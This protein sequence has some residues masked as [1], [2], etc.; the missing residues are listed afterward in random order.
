[1]SQRNML[2]EKMME[3]I[4]SILPITAIVAIVCFAI[5]PVPSGLMLAFLLGALMMIVGMGLF[6]LGA[7]LSM[8]KIGGHIGSKMTTTRK[9]WLILVLLEV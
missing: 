8:S 4:R 5:V 1:M 3:S 7:D 6:S 2:T 9:L